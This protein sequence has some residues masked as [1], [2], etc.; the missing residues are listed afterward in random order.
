VIRALA[1]AL[2]MLTGFSGLVYEVAW[3]KLLATLLGSQSEATAAILGLFL[4]G[5]SVGYSLFGGVTHRLSIRAQRRG[6][7][8]RLLV[9]YGCVEGSIG[10]WAIAFP[11]LF[12]LVQHA[13]VKLPHAAGGAGF[14]LDVALAA[15][16]VLPPAV[17]MGGTIPILTQALA[18]GLADATRFHALVYAVNTAGA[19]VGALAAGFWLVPHLGL[20]GVL[21]AMGG[22]NLGAGALF[23]VL[24][25]TARPT[26]ALPPP[27][28]PPAAVPPRFASLAAVALLSGFAMMTVQTVL[29]RIGALAF[30]AS[31]FTFSMV[32]AVFV[33]CIAAGSFG[34]SALRRIR[35]VHVVAS[36]WALV[37][38]LVLL[39]GLFQDAP[40]GA[41]VL[42]SLFRDTDAA[43]WPFQGAAFL[44]I[45]GLLALPVGLSGALLPLLFH[46]LRGEVEDLGAVA[47]RLYSWNTVGSLLGA[48]VGGYAL[49]FVLDL[50]QVYRLAVAA[51]VIAS[52]WLSVRLL[53]V[54]RTTLGLL[55][56]APALGGLL[57]L[58]RWAPERLAAGLFRFRQ[59]EANTYRGA[60]AL[61]GE[62]NRDTRILFYDDD[63]VS[64]VAVK[65][66]RDPA[67]G[68][69]RSIANNGKSD[70]SIPTDM[71]T[72]VLAAALPAVLADHCERAFV[73]GY[74]T[75]VTAG[76]L[77]S[78]PETREVVVSEI[79]PAV[80]A[81]AP[82]FDYG[83]HGA[84]RSPKVHAV[85]GDA[86]R[87]LLRSR[88]RFDVIVSEP[89][90]PWVTGVEM[91]Y[92]RE[93]LQAALD[94]LNPG[95]VYAQWF[96]VYE[97]DR[98]TV[99]LVMR[100]YDAVFDRVAVWYA[101]GTDPLLLGFAGGEHALDLDR[102]ERR[103]A[104]PALAASLRRAEVG[105][106]PA[107]LAHELLPLG[108]VQAA[109]FRGD[110]HTLLH[111]VLSHRAARAFLRGAIAE[112]PPTFAP[113][114]ARVGAENSLLRR[115]AARSGGRLPDALRS[116]AVQEVCRRRPLECATQLAAWLHDAPDA[117]LPRAIAARARSEPGFQ[118]DLEPG[119]LAELGVLFGEGP[120]GSGG[121][122]PYDTA[123][124]ATNLFVRYYS[125]AAPFPRAVLAGMWDRCIDE[126]GRCAA[127]MARAES[128]L[129]PLTASREPGASEPRRPTTAREDRASAPGAG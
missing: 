60:T 26:A 98:A 76:E 99:E 20:D 93:F 15:L 45:L 4:G 17:L 32:V 77:A 36:Q 79:S 46:Q 96:H 8:P 22:V 1:L 74:G 43:F 118:E 119:R 106:L 40:Y 63:P 97:T 110:V 37:A 115:L 53:A 47:G 7:A 34:V 51:L 54:S 23:L 2:T 56:V 33:L 113:Q 84:S 100:T 105:S 68:T 95:G 114:P 72:M 86:Y 102:L 101:H 57:L 61:Y 58:P 66:L 90:N 55:V 62:L 121:P 104:E 27:G 52:A 42:R 65:E 75:G 88:E 129:G 25:A 24:G 28:G 126:A 125:H 3:Q 35:P 39:D 70:G 38:C 83:N 67:L 82:F 64:S 21:L 30:G 103:I 5:L 29:N 81:A 124:R 94:H 11:A 59:P 41:H 73:I 19:F 87:S 6:R 92:S 13:S 89:S 116:Q 91:L 69:V 44:A 109:G 123:A 107:L 12:R 120:G 128:W 48:L 14:V 78:Y 31:Q 122:V 117:S 18:R 71:P 85:I 9:A 10:L 111:P 49:L 16:L 108:V 80:L 127:G 50:D 112:L